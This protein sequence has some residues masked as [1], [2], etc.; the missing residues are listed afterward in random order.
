[1]PDDKSMVE[2]FL[3]QVDELI[4]RPI[5]QAGDRLKRST[6]LLRQ[7]REQCDAWRAGK[8]QHVRN[9]TERVNEL[10]LAK[11]I[12]EDA[13]VTDREYE[14]AVPG[15]DKTIDFLVHPAAD[16]TVQLFYDVKTVHPEP[17]DSW[18]L[19]ERATAEGWW[20]PNT[21]LIL[22]K[23]WL[24]AEIAHEKFASRYRF[25]EHTLA[26]ERKIDQM[27]R[28]DGAY[29]RMVFCGDGFKWH[30]TELEDFAETYFT[31]AYPGDHFAAIQRHYMQQQGQTFRRSI[32]GFCCLTRA[33]RSPAVTAFRIDLRAPR[34]P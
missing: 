10:C 7:Y 31:G 28:G 27:T 12:L 23:E 6:K 15:T 3:A 17:G 5:E 11:L 4:V 24:G 19:Y 9:I 29:F 32:S 34:F 1:M 8:V 30:L 25:F 16:H 26:L 18:A 2:S 33:I 13:S 20:T 14:A 22:E 21:E